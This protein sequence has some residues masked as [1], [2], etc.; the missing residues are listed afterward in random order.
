MTW[1]KTL[2]RWL[3]LPFALTGGLIVWLWRRAVGQAK[4]EKRL[5][6]DA[7]A[8][9]EA[10]A[11]SAERERLAGAA[12]AKVDAER[13]TAGQIIEAKR[14]AAVAKASASRAKVDAAGDD[15]KALAAEGN[16]RWRERQGQ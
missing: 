10:Q 9:E 2:G 3:W 16:R 1:I 15:V 12:V 7:E 8:R 13:R 11:R 5:R 6:L 4:A 14:E